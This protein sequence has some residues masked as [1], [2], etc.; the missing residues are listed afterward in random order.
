MEEAIQKRE[1]GMA[2][3]KKKEKR[4]GKRREEKRWDLKEKQW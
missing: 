3:R 1:E 2:G 4:R